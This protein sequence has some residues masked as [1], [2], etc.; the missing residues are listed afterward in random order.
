VDCGFEVM[1]GE[2][3]VG[4]NGDGE[5]LAGRHR[6]GSHIEESLGVCELE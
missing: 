6:A 3:A 5:G 4:F 2:R 1:D